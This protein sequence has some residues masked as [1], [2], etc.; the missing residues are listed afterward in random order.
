MADLKEDKQNLLVE[1]EQEQEL[2][3]NTLHRKISTLLAEKESL[4]QRLESEQRFI[5]GHLAKR[6]EDLEGEK[7]YY[8]LCGAVLT[9]YRHIRKRES[10]LEEGVFDNLGQ[11]LESLLTSNSA[12]T[13]TQLVA[14]ISEQ[15]ESLRLKYLDH[16][17]E[18]AECISF[19]FFMHLTS[20]SIHTESSIEETS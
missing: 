13:R 14:R 19:L 18:F 6:V 3:T 2:L 4:V 7:L 9:F 12:H 17:S 15:I 5:D 1:L 8:P 10:F 11:L 20:V 16:Q